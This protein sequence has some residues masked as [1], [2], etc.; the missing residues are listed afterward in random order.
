MRNG[1]SGAPLELPTS[2]RVP[3]SW[4][5]KHASAP[6]RWRTVR[7]I[8]PQGAASEVDQLALLEETLAYKPIAQAFKKQKKTGIW[9]DGILGLGVSRGQS[10]RDVGM[11]SQYRYLVEAGVPAEQRAFRLAERVFFRLLSRD[12]DPALLFEFARAARG[13]PEFA[14]WCRAM[15]RQAATVALAHAGHTEDPRVRGAAHRIASDVSQFLRSELAEKPFVRKGSRTILHPDANPPTILAVATFAYMPSLQRERA[16]FIERLCAYLAQPAPKRPYSIQVGKRTAKPS[17][18]LLGDPLAADAAGR[19]KDFPLAL[20]WIEVLARL[21]MLHTSPT[22][23]RVLLRLVSECD[24]QGVWSPPNLR[25]L[26]KSPS[27]LADFVFP[28]SVDTKSPE[29][30]KVDVTF[31]LALIAKLAGWTLEFT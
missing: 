19:T 9:G 1:T 22:A 2:H 31:R 6:V 11:V 14:N 21:N 28:L 27:R 5:R 15:M 18:E 4:L 29:G 17:F 24:P 26:P 8:L 7:D 13:S 3:I 16:G 12:E 23:Q 20:H 10:A 30:R 25:S